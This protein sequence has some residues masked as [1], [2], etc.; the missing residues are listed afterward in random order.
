[1]QQT[2]YL[3]DVGILLSPEDEEYEQYSNVYDKQHGFY[4]EDQS[5]TANLAKAIQ[6]A[7]DY[8]TYGVENTYAVISEKYVSDSL[9]ETDIRSKTVKNET[10]DME[11]VL[12]S[13]QKK[14][15]KVI[16]L[17][18]TLVQKSGNIEPEQKAE[19]LGQLID[20]VEAFITTHHQELK[21]IEN[22]EEFV[23][24]KDTSYDMLHESFKTMMQLWNIIPTDTATKYLVYEKNYL[25]GGDVDTVDA[26]D[27][28]LW[29]TEAAAKQDMLERKA[30]YCEEKNTFTFMENESSDVCFVFADGLIP[31]TDDRSGEFHICMQP[32]EENKGQ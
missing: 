19:F 32:L 12:F 8:V 17:M 30:K 5:Y 18:T 9:T 16:P 13:L 6:E 28:K 26:V 7:L 23:F 27:M 14:D 3:L 29:A 24:L 20:I 25:S 1:M 11:D 21:H 15:G 2:C 31:K 22:P 10:Y 4:D